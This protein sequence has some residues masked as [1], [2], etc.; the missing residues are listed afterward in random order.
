MPCTDRRPLPP[1]AGL[2]NLQLVPMA[3]GRARVHYSL[4]STVDSKFTRLGSKVPAFKDHLTRHL[5]LDGDHALLHVQ[6]RQGF[7]PVYAGN[8]PGCT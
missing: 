1:R 2:M 8:S 5:V 7:G 4:L 6:V 3:P